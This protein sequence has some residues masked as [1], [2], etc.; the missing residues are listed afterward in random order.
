MTPL[1]T[2][3]GIVKRLTIARDKLMSLNLSCWTFVL[4][5]PFFFVRR[6]DDLF[7]ILLYLS[8]LV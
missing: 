8:I 6:I 3:N 5:A 7:R 1:E 4:V 2:K